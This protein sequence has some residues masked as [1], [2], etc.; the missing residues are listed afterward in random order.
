M[1]SKREKFVKSFSGEHLL[2]RNRLTDHGVWQIIGPAM[3]CEGR[4]PGKVIAFYEGVLD[5]VIDA[6]LAQKEFW[7]GYGEPGAIAFIKIIQAVDVETDPKQ[8]AIG[9]ALAKLT[10]EERELLGL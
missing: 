10:D 9:E 3:D 8:I 6:A 1:L 2:K 5:I 7:N 4:T